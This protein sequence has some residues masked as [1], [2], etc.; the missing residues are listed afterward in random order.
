M[1]YTSCNGPVAPGQHDNWRL[2]L[3]VYCLESEFSVAESKR[4]AVS[5][6]MRVLWRARTSVPSHTSFHCFG[7]GEGGRG[8]GGGKTR[9]CRRRCKVGAP[10]V[11]FCADFQRG[12]ARQ[13]QQGQAGKCSQTQI[14]TA[15]L[16]L[17]FTHASI[18]EKT[19]SPRLQTP[20]E[21]PFNELR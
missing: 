20:T 1:S 13:S 18:H 6:C 7:E 15:L 12:M 5:A 3:N 17:S 4:Q 16:P 14:V 10:I 11:T 2:A 9:H 19:K 8:R 21:V